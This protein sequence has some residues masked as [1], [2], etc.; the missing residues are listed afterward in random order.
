[1]KKILLF[2]IVF[3]LGI[4]VGWFGTSLPYFQKSNNVGPLNR[5]H[6]YPA[7]GHLIDPIIQDEFQQARD[8]Q[9][10]GI[11]KEM[12]SYIQKSIANGSAIKVSVYLRDFNKA[13]WV[14]INEDAKYSSAS[15]GKVPLMFTIYLKAQSDP[16]LLHKKI[17]YAVPIESPRYQVHAPQARLQLGQEYT[18]D[19]LVH[20]MIV[21]SDNIS[22]LLLGYDQDID[23]GIAN[24]LL[25]QLQL[26][27]PQKGQGDYQISA[28]DYSSFFRMLYRATYL[29]RELSEK[30]L[31]LLTESEFNKGIVGGLPRNTVVAHKF[32]ESGELGREVQ[33]H[34]C[35]IVYFPEHPYLICI[36]TRGQ[37]FEHLEQVIE[38]LSNIA[39]D[40]FSSIPSKRP[41]S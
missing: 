28:K 30:A 12:E 33:L 19:E 13:N 21:Y 6:Y 24:L 15:L 4:A 20:N 37:D 40:G 5:L 35:G 26:P 31:G 14:G 22:L 41:A 7:G 8:T 18:V 23:L 2:I 3:L 38:G 11:K 32:G 9:L 17:R 10:E 39:Y 27:I 16:G 25:A 29:N 1:M 34:D 36:M